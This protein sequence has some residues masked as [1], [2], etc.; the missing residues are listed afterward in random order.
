MSISMDFYVKIL[1]CLPDILDKYLTKSFFMKFLSFILLLAAR[2]SYAT[3]KTHAFLK[4]KSIIIIV[5]A[6][7]HL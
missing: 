6:N 4:K 3:R 7:T 1:Q 5:T 2:I